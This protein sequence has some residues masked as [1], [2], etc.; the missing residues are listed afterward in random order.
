MFC[1]MDTLEE[2]FLPEVSKEDLVTITTLP[3]SDSRFESNRSTLAFINRV[4]S[5]SA[6]RSFAPNS[7]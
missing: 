6:I 7:E 1:G 2:I 3:V 5:D 4:L